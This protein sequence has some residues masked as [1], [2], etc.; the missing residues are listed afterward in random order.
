MGGKKALLGI[1]L[2]RQAPWG[3]RRAKWR[4]SKQ[5]A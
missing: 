1:K 5:I 3:E 2:P 4:K